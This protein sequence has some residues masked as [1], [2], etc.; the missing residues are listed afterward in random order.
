MTPNDKQIDVLLRRYGKGHGET[1]VTEHL[2]ADEMNS[3]AEGSLPAATRARY[4]SHL[5]ECDRCRSEVTQLAISAG[6]V[7]RAEQAVPEKVASPGFWHVLA[8]FFALP[9]LRYAAFA[10]VVLIVAGVG[11]IV[12]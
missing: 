9:I 7:A 2:D 10:A 6:A 4:V 12:M 3:F 8:G 11:V 5:A 1:P